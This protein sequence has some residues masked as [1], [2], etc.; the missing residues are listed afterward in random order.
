[1]FLGIIGVVIA[2]SP[3][4]A[5][6]AT[7]LWYNGNYDLN[8]AYTDQNNV[9]INFGGSYV[10]DKSLVYD[11]FI[12]PVGQSWTLSSLFVDDQLDY[13][14]LPTT[15]T[16][17]IR[18]GM[19]AGQGGTLL[20]SGDTAATNTL[21]TAA[22]G[23]SYIDP[24]YKISAAVTGVTIGP[25]VYWMAVAPD[26]AG[27]YGDQSYIETTSGTGAIGSPAGNDGN[28]FLNNNLSGPGHL[29]FAPSSLDFSAGVNGTAT[30]VPEPASLPMLAAGLALAFGLGQRGHRPALCLA[31]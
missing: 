27:Y 24:E 20:F 30:L 10:L 2:L 18:S 6:A 21:L 15:A 13:Y 16:W 26:S 25:G 17:E 1:M 23:N 4:R 29:S 9:P 14:A 7:S 22:N 11:D 12:V 19:S 3:A 5:V 8:D 28:S 31:V